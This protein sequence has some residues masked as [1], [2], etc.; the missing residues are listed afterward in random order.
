[1]RAGHLGLLVSMLLSLGSA[2]AFAGG[3]AILDQSIEGIGRASA[4]EGAFVHDSSVVFS[5]PAGMTDLDRPEILVGTHII[6]VE[7]HV[8]SKS[9]TLSSP[10]I[11]GTVGTGGGNGDPLG[12]DAI[13]VVSASAP[14]W[15]DRV[16]LGFAL[17]VP[18]GLQSEY[19]EGWAGRYD[20]TKSELLTMNFQPS[21][22][23]RVT[24]WL[25]LGIGLDVQYADA[26]L[27]NMLPNVASGVFPT[28]DGKLKVEGDDW[29]AGYNLGLLV[30]VPQSKTRIGFH[31]RSEMKHELD[32][33]VVFS[34]LTGLLAGQ[35]GKISAKADLDLPEIFTLSVSQPVTEKWTVMATYRFIGWD[36]FGEIRVKMGDGQVLSS[37]ENYDDSMTLAL[38]T[39]Y[40][41]N[42]EW[43]VRTGFQFDQSPTRGGFRSTRVPDGD[44]F[45]ITL[46]TTYR[47]KNW[48]ELQASWAHLFFRDEDIDR[49]VTIYEGTGL[50][51]VS[52]VKADIEAYAD[53]WSL[54]AVVRF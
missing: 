41:V 6:R 34:G 38:G 51:T 20:S 33:N 12:T 24:D 27:E 3:F 43:N 8:K 39:E 17:N 32:G 31:Y 25:S 9:S 54:A 16:W 7:A 22:A 26:T 52:R 13:P 23:V 14:V 30:E 49:S 46:G 15:K 47:V 40:A 19:S 36:S 2:T 5:N 45:W 48:L 37:K 53:I 50:D 29:S 11:G 28:P 35:N 18:F 10:L 4:G 44:R 21:A 42:D 1:M